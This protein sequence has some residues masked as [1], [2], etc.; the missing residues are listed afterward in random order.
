MNSDEQSVILMLIGLRNPFF[1]LKQ[2]KGC[3]TLYG[4]PDQSV[5]PK[6]EW[7]NWSDTDNVEIE[8]NNFRF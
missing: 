4:S 1:L 7:I 6:F 2:A 8:H 3:A 5:P